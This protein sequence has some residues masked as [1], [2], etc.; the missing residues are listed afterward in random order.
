MKFSN[1]WLGFCQY[2]R[3]RISINLMV[4]IA[5]VIVHENLHAQDNL[6]ASKLTE[7]K[8]LKLE[9]QRT[10]KMTK[11]EARAIVKSFSSELY[12]LIL[13]LEKP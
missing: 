2:S 6:P 8:V 11:G 1:V 3:K 9:K 7:Q 4:V 12:R 10:M 13:K 5:G